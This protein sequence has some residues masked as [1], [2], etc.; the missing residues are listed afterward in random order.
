VTNT[1]LTPSDSTV[2][3]PVKGNIRKFL[4]DAAN[5]DQRVNCL[6]VFTY[7]GNIPYLV[8]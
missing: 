1:Y 8:R 5:P 3:L 7:G 4:E 6:D 2:Q